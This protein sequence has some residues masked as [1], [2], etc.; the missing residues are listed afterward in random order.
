M[1]NVFWLLDGGMVCY[2]L[3]GIYV[4]EYVGKVEHYRNTQGN[5]KV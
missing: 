4:R 1:M 5:R 3:A 2:M